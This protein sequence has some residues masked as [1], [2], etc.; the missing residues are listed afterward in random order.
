MWTDHF[1]LTGPKFETPEWGGSGYAF[2]SGKVAM[3]EN[4]LWTT[5]GVAD[6]GDDWDLAPIPSHNGVT[7]S[8]LNADTFAIHRDTD[9][10]TEAFAALSYLLG[11]A[12][13]ELLGI[14]GGM[15][16]RT[17]QQDAFFAS[18][19][20]QFPHDVDWQVAKDSLAYADNPNFEAYMPKY[21]ET[22]DLL[23]VYNTKW[24]TTPG[25]DM[26]AEIAALESEIQAIW[27]R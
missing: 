21:N 9:H 18:L 22:L 15:P 16:A 1:I 25:L 26:D 27:D 23:G 6:A 10:P 5:Y 14:Y 17:D 8:P 13:P 12:A 11:E 20:E 2:F 4:F 7:T 24:T 3:S 19:D